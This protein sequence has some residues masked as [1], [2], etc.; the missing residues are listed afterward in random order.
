MSTEQFAVDGDVAGHAEP[1]VADLAVDEMIQFER[2]GFVRLDA[3][4][5]EP[6]PSGYGPTGEEDLVAYYAHP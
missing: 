4:D 2:V 3:F 1:G 6:A 5:P